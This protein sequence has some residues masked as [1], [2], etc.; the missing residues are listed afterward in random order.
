MPARTRQV[1]AGAAHV[2]IAALLLSSVAILGC[3]GLSSPASAR[4]I[5]I[6]YQKAGTL[7][8]AKTQ[9]DFEK[10]LRATGFEV[11]WTEFPAGPQLLEALHVG[12]IDFGHTGDSPPIF[13]QAAGVPFVYVA[14][15]APSPAGSAILVPIDSPLKTLADLKGKKIAFA[16]GSSANYLV[17]AALHKAG[18]SIADVE[19][20]HLIP[21]DARAAF[22]SG[23]VDA[24]AI[25][26][27]Y[28]A[29]AEQ[30][31]QARV[32]VDGTGLVS[33]REFYLAARD[34]SERHGDAL[35]LI[36]SEVDRV[37]RWAQENPDVVAKILAPE[38]GIEV[39]VL[40]KAERRRGRHDV[41]SIDAVMIAEQ[42]QVAESYVKAGL[43]PRSITVADAVRPP[44]T[45]GP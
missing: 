34:F 27:P 10:N 1:G 39:N 26:D 8:L 29:L 9:G 37:G 22:T 42:Q 40:E 21:S 28:F 32:L 36:E 31:G 2:A 15:S 35:R 12:S 18:L 6:G 11:T 45:P 43:I 7:A 16:K 25:W 24:W 41:Q 38:L 30:A 33:G 23:A 4:V 14:A 44:T 5:R 19:P 13:A 3:Q 17:L 20:I